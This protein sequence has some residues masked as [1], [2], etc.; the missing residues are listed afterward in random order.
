MNQAGPSDV[1]QSTYFVPRS[2]ASKILED[3]RRALAC[4]MPPEVIEN[5]IQARYSI[6][7]FLPC[8]GGAHENA[9]VDHCSVCAPRWGWV[10]KGI[11]VR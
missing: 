3:I 9:H 4:K 11:K 7:P 5:L 1:D 2:V 6:D 8:P 10:G